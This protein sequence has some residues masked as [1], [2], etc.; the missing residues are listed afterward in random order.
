MYRERR[1]LARTL[2]DADTVFDDLDMLVSVIVLVVI[3][4]VSLLI[5]GLL[6]T[7]T[8]IFISSQLLLVVF[9]FGNTARTVFEAVIFIFVTHPFDV[10]DRCV[11]D[12]VQVCYLVLRLRV[13]LLCY[14]FPICLTSE[15]VTVGC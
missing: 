15:F 4:I 11:I 7:E 5:M 1:L 12:G 3:T 9:M 2:K 6:T 10:K 8:L 14:R 13:R